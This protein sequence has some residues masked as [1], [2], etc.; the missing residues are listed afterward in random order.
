MSTIVNIEVQRDGQVVDQKSFN[1][2]AI[3][4]GGR[5]TSDLHLDGEG[6][7]RIHAVIEVSGADVRLVDLGSKGG[8]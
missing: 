5:A 8:T 1:K 3:K 7:A 2:E 6:V 4:I